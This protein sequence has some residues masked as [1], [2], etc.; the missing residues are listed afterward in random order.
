MSCFQIAEG[1]YHDDGEAGRVK[2]TAFGRQSSA[3]P[4]LS[5]L[6]NGQSRMANDQGPTTNDALLSLRIQ[7]RIDLAI[8]AC[9]IAGCGVDGLGPLL[10][11]AVELGL[12]Q[13][14]GSLEDGIERIA[15]VVDKNAETGDDFRRLGGV[16]RGGAPI[17]TFSKV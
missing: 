14:I 4:L 15:Q 7:D 1:K 16:F 3:I 10:V 5:I 2:E 17:L 13:K 11:L 12:L 9:C 6:G 8:N